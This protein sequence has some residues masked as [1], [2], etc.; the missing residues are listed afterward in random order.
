MGMRVLILAN[1]EPPADREWAQRLAAAHDLLIATDGAAHRAVG[2]GLTPDI[3]CG[4]FNSIRM[5]AAQA[6]FPNAR[7]LP[8]PDQEQADLEKA[9][10]V[11]QEQG[12]ASITIIGATGGRLD[13]TLATFA[14]LLQPHRALPITLRTPDTAVQALA[15]TAE[16][17]GECTLSTQPDDTISLLSFDGLARIT[18][19]GVRWPLCE[20]RLQ[21]ATRG[22]SNRAVADQVRVRVHGGAILICHLYRHAS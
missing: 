16:A 2:L 9:L 22:V 11:A 20:E 7:F 8:T 19:T 12:A 5:E 3:V 1:G 4:D 14:L 21:F 18:L 15:G 13:H 6:E 17:P 10:L